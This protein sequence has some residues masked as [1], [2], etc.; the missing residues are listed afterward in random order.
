LDP[1]NLAP[2]LELRYY[3]LSDAILNLGP[4]IGKMFVNFQQYLY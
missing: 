1:D 4:E 3:A 2:L